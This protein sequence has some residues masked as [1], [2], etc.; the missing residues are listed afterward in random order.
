MVGCTIAHYEVLDKLG[1]GGMGVVYKARDTRLDRLVALKL[2]PEDKTADAQHRERLIR[3]AK[4]ASALNH[5]NIITVYDAGDEHGAVFIAMEYVD[6][7]MLADVI[8]RKGLGLKDTLRYGIQIADALSAAHEAGIIHRDL[9]PGNVMVSEK[10]VVKVLDFG[11]AKPAEPHTPL[12]GE[13]TLTQNGLTE[14]GMV[15]GTAAYMSPEQ[16]EGKHVDFRSDIFSFGAVLFEMITGHRAFEKESNLSTLAAVL[17]QN[18]GP[19]PAAIPRELVTVVA[20]CLRK[21]A[22]RRFQTMADVKLELEELKDDSE[23]GKLAS[24]PARTP[25]SRRGWLWAALA[26]AALVAAAVVWRVPKWEPQTDIKAVALTSYPGTESQPAFSPDGNKVAFVWNGRNEDSPNIY[27]KQIGAPGPPLRLTTRS[28]LE[29]NP[30]WSPDD[31]WIA[32]QRTENGSTSI[33][34]VPPLGGPERILYSRPKRAFGLCWMPD[35]R[36]LIYAE[37]GPSSDVAGLWAISIETGERHRLTNPQLKSARAIESGLGDEFPA[38]SPDG[39]A[40]VL[41]RQTGGFVVEVWALRLKPDCTPDGEPDRVLDHRYAMFG[42]LCWTPDSREIVYASGGLATRSLW[43]VPVF[44]KRAPKRLSFVT[45]DASWPVLAG[46]TRRLAYSWG[47]DNEDIWRLDTRTGEK[48]MLI[49]STYLSEIPQYSPDGRRI[50]FQS[51]RSG[52]WEVW[53][54]DAE[55]GD[56]LQL[57]QFQGPQ[58]GSPAWSPD[59]RWLA[60]DSRAEAQADIYVMPADGGAPRR[61]TDHPADDVQPSWSPDGRWIYFTSDR[62]GQP[63]IWRIPAPGGGEAVRMTQNGA[64]RGFASPDGSY[65]YFTKMPQRSLFRVPANGGAEVQILPEVS[66]ESCGFTREGIYCLSPDRKRIQFFD[67]A[68]SRTRALATLDKPGSNI[69]ASPDGRYILW[70][71][72]DRRIHDLM[73]VEN[74]R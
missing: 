65:V 3:E 31:R 59:G 32:F 52:D 68:T 45:P 23:S 62:S 22:A 72:V 20:R 67:T 2:L 43:Q 69:T 13:R 1:E 18:P 25:L 53:T 42:G 50:A 71:Q 54:C 35:S 39:R 11:L 15:V 5:P 46:R 10:G 33:V 61:I 21:D 51:N 64:Q 58:C 14:P 63:E 8:P 16:A 74:F 29:E 37:R 6:G 7:K 19:L 73:M 47:I 44:A 49:G 28:A 36:W 38:V 57:T 24:V 12:A 4:A 34:L 27:V 41:A 30:A 26:A 56:C 9:K 17:T 40:V 70:E 48:R 55:G 60:L 66:P